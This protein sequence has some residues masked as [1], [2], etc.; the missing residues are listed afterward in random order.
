M[1]DNHLIYLFELGLVKVS[2]VVDGNPEYDLILGER[3]NKDFYKNIEKS[4]GKIC[5]EDACRLFARRLSENKVSAYKVSSEPGILAYGSTH[6]NRKEF[7]FLSDLL[8]RNGYRGAVLN[9]SDCLS[10][11][12]SLQPEQFCKSVLEIIGH[13]FSSRGVVTK[14]LL[15]QTLN[16][17]R[18][19]FGALAALRNTKAKL[20]VVAN[21]HS[22]TT[23]AYTMA[24]RFYGLKTLYVQ[25][26]EVTAIFPRNDFDFSIFRN[27][28]SRN[29]YREIGPLTGSS[30]CLSRIS[31]GLTTDKIKASRQGLRNSPSPSVVIYPSS[32]LLPEKLK[33]L[34][35][36]LRNNGYL[37]DIK[38]KP[39]PAFGKRNILTALNVDL[40]NEIPNHPHI[41]ICGNSSVV[42][43]LLA[44]GNLVYQDFSLDSISDDY[45]GFVEKGLADRFSIN[46]CRE[47]FWSKGEEFEGWLVNLGD[48]LP[49]LDTA[50]NSIEKER[51]G[52]FLRNMLFSSQLVDELD[53]EVS[54]EF[55]FCRDLFYFTNSFL[56]LVRSKGCVYGSD[57][58]MIRQLNAYF[59]KRDI[60]LNVLYGRASPEIC[61][62]VLD[63]WLI[64]KKIEWTGYRPTQENIK[65]L[66]EFSKSYSS[67]YSA[68]S[69]VES[70]IFEVLLRYSK[71]EDLNHFLEN[72]R[73][74]SVATSSIN[75][76]IAFVRYV[77]SFPEDR[78]FLL[79]YFDYRNAHLT[80]LERLKVS[81]QCL[82]K[83]NG[84]LEYSDYQVVEQAFLQA[85]TPIVKEYK[86]TVIASYAA[87]RDR[88]VLID[89]KRNLHQEKKF[90]GLIK[91]RL[92]SR[93]GFSFI[94][95]SDGEGYI[96]QDFSQH[97]TESDACNR[98]RHWWGREI[99]L[100]IRAQ[101]ILNTVDAVKNADVLGIPS[102]Y[103]FLRDHSDRSVSLEN[104]IQGRGLLSVLQGI[105]V[106]DQ[107]RALYTDDK[108]NIAIFNKIENI[109]YLCKFA[110]KLI[111]ISS[112]SSECLKKAFGESFNFHLI[113]IPTHNKTQLNERYITCDKPLPYIYKD[114][115]DEILEI[116][117]AGDLVLVGAGVSG[118]A[119]MDAAKQKDAVGLDLGSVMDELLNAG[120]HSLR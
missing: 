45:Y 74:F 5:Q 58:W 115:Y 100:D 54:R 26:A 17:S 70:K 76:R 1:I 3:L 81:V 67:E 107:G 110:K 103:R 24:A 7:A 28:A 108:A 71:A 93:T 42:I 104:S 29:L 119:F 4:D 77:Q 46:T 50:F 16:Y 120:I 111:V 72:S 94:R 95:L 23:V 33:V 96:F 2:S 79:K 47:K 88:A 9:V 113:N 97:F 27:Q 12:V 90:I 82:L 84:R 18:T 56:S 102:V 39:H 69:W 68:L 11:R 99:P 36:R 52:L 15:H 62:S 117:E 14:S 31:D 44:C 86:S 48:Y 51:E 25:H 6:N 78:G 98:E 35:S 30:I 101:L 91:N 59:D 40:I 109:R 89:V 37:T 57:S 43:E 41:A 21:D 106:V 73:R 13:F 49:N 65:S 32:V 112:G 80:P 10:E 92:I 87:I 55:Y 53:N 22:P 85:H 61:K 20:F 38:V 60:R 64:T 114:V 19:F 66:I 75:R 63:F 8:I 116:A 34:L 105:Q 83:S 118:K